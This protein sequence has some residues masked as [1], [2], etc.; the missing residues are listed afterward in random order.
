M[1]PTH[2][3]CI[4]STSKMFTTMG[5]FRLIEEGKLTTADLAKHVYEEPDL[6]GIPA[7]QLGFGYGLLT[8]N[9]L[10]RLKTVNLHHLLTHTAMIRRSGDTLETSVNLGI[11][12]NQVTYPDA[13]T[14][15]FGF[16]H[17]VTTEA[18]GIVKS[19]S[20]HGLGQVGWLTGIVAQREYGENTDTYLQNHVL[21][22]I[23][24][25]H[26]RGRTNWLHEETSR[27]AY[28]YL[29]YTTGSVL[30]HA[31]SYMTGHN[32]PRQYEQTYNISNAAGGWTA[33][34]ADLV[35][36]MCAQDGLAN[37]A[38][39]LSAPVRQLLHSRPFGD[40]TVDV[41]GN[42]TAAHAHGWHFDRDTE[43]LSHNGDIGYG[44]SYLMMQPNDGVIDGNLNW[45]SNSLAVAVCLNTS[46]T[47]VATYIATELRDRLLT[48]AIPWWYDLLGANKLN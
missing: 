17:L 42:A 5:L 36:L 37:H 40:M 21:K 8:T 7:V 35:R 44:S 18:P 10:D 43:T 20:N 11:P 25:Q 26:M 38:D 15:F 9:E 2:R 16:H 1:L 24:I 14:N 13:I 29:Y 46:N 3:T 28:R 4:G 30:P 39:R 19:Y 23:G 47:S 6:L 31:D 45:N 12:F 27:D 34:A 33:C 32:G 48:A 22:P 41:N